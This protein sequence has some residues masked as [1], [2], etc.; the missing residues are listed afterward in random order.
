MPVD[1]DQ[2]VAAAA[3]SSNTPYILS[4]A[5][6]GAVTLFVTVT[7]YIS[8]NKVADKENNMLMVGEYKKLAEEQ[9][10]T[11]TSQKTELDALRAKQDK[12]LA[13]LRK[14]LDDR[15]EVL[16]AR[17]DELREQIHQYEVYIVRNHLE[18][19]TDGA[20]STTHT[21]LPP[22]QEAK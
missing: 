1:P 7:N 8:K 16:A 2:A 5:V 20:G 4:A 3:T 18:I 10:K 14:D 19:P 9:V 13:D 21:A 17:N 12:G 22:K 15:I 6:G 11:I